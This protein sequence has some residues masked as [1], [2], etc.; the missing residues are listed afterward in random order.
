M[1]GLRGLC[2]SYQYIYPEFNTM[3][4]EEGIVTNKIKDEPQII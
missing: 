3:F 1:R 4:G 2:Y